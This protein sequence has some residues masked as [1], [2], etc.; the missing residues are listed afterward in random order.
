M[1]DTN[2]IQNW[3]VIDY[4]TGDMNIRKTQPSASELGKNEIMTEI[5]VDVITP[6][7]DFEPLSATLEVPAP[8]VRDA[9]IEDLD[10]GDVRTW[11]EV[12]DDILD[13][14]GHMFVEDGELVEGRWLDH[15]AET[16]VE[17]FEA[18]VERPD[19]ADVR[20]YL[21]DELR[22]RAE[23]TDEVTPDA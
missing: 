19:V 2:R 10:D 4:K 15:E 3:I 18:S 21:T 14:T 8:T 7:P 5:S 17:V 11:Q 9:D 6:E 22:R 20:K 13:R 16:V 12:A 1:T 23:P